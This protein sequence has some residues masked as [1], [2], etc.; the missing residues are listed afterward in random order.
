MN[1]NSSIMSGSL[2]E[3][4][5]FRLDFFV[6]ICYILKRKQKEKE[7]KNEVSEQIQSKGKN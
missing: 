5:R 2:I 4:M 3:M 1:Q 7:E 6:K